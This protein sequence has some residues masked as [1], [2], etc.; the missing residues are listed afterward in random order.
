MKFFAFRAKCKGINTR[1]L[2]DV[3]L[4]SHLVVKK[5]STPTLPKNYVKF[6]QN[7]IEILVHISFEILFA[8]RISTSIFLNIMLCFFISVYLIIFCCLVGALCHYSIKKFRVWF[9]LTFFHQIKAITFDDFNLNAESLVFQ[10]IY[11]TT[12][13]GKLSNGYSYIILIGFQC[14]KEFFK[15]TFR[16]IW[17]ILQWQYWMCSIVLVLVYVLWQ[18]IVLY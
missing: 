16:E 11:F 14:E 7:F 5:S 12:F 8:F 6:D 17:F 2:I 13:S 4:S 10:N 3:I 15:N 18:C 1:P 9:I